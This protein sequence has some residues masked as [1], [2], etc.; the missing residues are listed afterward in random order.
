MLFKIPLLQRYIFGEVLR[1]FVFVLGCM[2]V[3][4]VFVGIFQQATAAGLDA[5]QAF[6]IIPYVVPSMLPFTIPAALLLTVSVV[7]GR[8][9]GDQ[10]ITAAK[11]AG[12]HPLS[13]MWP[14]FLLGAMLSV[15]SLLMTDQVAPWSMQKIQSHIVNFMEDIFLDRLR[16]EHHFSD[17]Q[18]GLLVTVEAVDGNR[19]IHPTFRYTKG[20]RICTLQAEEA[21]IDLDVQEQKVTI[22]ARNA[23]FDIPG[24][25][26]GHL[27]HEVREELRWNTSERSKKPPELPILVIQKELGRMAR[28]RERDR[29]RMLLET[30]FALTMADFHRLVKTGVQ[31]LAGM[32]REAGRASALNTEIHSRYA[33]ACSC[34]F[35]ALLG[36]PFSIR[37]GKSQYLTSFLLCFLPIVGGYYP[38]MLGLVTQAKKGTIQPEWSMWVANLL[39]AVVAC[40]MMRRVIRY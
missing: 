18:H 20:Q 21:Q 1:V 36:T 19:L 9:T 12:I 33:M 32:D 35:F 4:L 26:R 38:L 7:Y 11:A 23:W 10:E 34:F 28:E 15:A 31:R 22:L 30:S 6:T 8:L 39:L 17:P 29:Q 2:T 5:V 40:A 14:A 27:L 37:F 13:L 24:K 25:A 3:L 16:T